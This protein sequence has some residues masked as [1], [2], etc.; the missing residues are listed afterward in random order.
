MAIVNILGALNTM[1]TA[2]KS[3]AGIDSVLS[4]M[5]TDVNITPVVCILLESAKEEYATSGQNRLISTY[6]IRVIVDKTSSDSTQVGVVLAIVDKILDE[7]RKGDNQ[8]LN[9]NGHFLQAVGCS[10]VRDDKIGNTFVWYCDITAE[11]R[12]FKTT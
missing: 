5:P 2:I 4:Y 11:V 6:T 10:P 8:Y 9:C 7:L 1:I 12:S 3:S